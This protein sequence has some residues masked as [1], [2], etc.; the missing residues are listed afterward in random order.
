MLS[1]RDPEYFVEKILSEFNKKPPEL[2]ANELEAFINIIF[3]REDSID[4]IFR[5][6]SDKSGQTDFHVML[7]M[8]QKV[9]G[10][11]YRDVMDMPLEIFQKM[12]DDLEIIT[13]SKP[14]DKDRNSNKP[15][16]KAFKDVF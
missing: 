8:F 9:T 3:R 13:G 1:W 10:N 5:K 14:Y 15:D 6:K 2:T 11:G 7:G 4:D 12:S 16:K